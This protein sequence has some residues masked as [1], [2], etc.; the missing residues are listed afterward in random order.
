MAIAAE[1][2]A[3]MYEGRISSYLREFF[4]LL[5]ICNTVVVSRPS[6]SPNTQENDHLDNTQ[7]ITVNS[8]QKGSNSTGGANS[9]TSTARTGSN[10][11]HKEPQ[12]SSSLLVDVA[13]NQS[14]NQGLVNKGLLPS[15]AKR[16]PKTEDSYLFSPEHSKNSYSSVDLKASDKTNFENVL[17]EAES[18]D[19][20]ALVKMAS[21][22]GFKLIS[23]SPNTVTVLIPNEGQVT[24]QVLHVLAFDSSRKRMSVVVRRGDGEILMYCKGADSA[25]MPRLSSSHLQGDD[26]QTDAGAQGEEKQ[27]MGNRRLSIAENTDNHLNMYARDGLRTLCMTRRVSTQARDILVY[28][29]P[30]F[31]KSRDYFLPYGISR[32][33]FT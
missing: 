3:N 12:A 21:S 23:R 27:V 19:E 14:S 33:D 24:F 13:E 20:E 2:K 28:D 11:E 22:Y 31:S 4:I 7:T 6:S 9:G 17:Y 1:S 30:P 18:P 29:F 8:E 32:E 15:P 26:D 10:I 25:V 16:S 5:A